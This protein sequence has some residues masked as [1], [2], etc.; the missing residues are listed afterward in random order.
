MLDNTD[1]THLHTLVR[2]KLDEI[3]LRLYGSVEG[4]EE[5][6][7]LRVRQGALEKVLAKLNAMS[8]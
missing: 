4:T 1:I 8:R 3:E 7:D 5:E 6:K 2:S